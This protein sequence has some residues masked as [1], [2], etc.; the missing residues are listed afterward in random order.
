VEFDCDS[1]HVFHTAYDDRSGEPPTIIRVNGKEFEG[2]V[3]FIQIGDDYN[4]RIKKT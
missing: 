3:S 2:E 4:I 1:L